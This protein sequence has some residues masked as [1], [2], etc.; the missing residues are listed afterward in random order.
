MRVQIDS[1]EKERVKS[2]SAY[3][4]SQGLDV[5]VCELESEIICSM[6]KFVL[7]LK[8]FQT[9]SQAFKTIGFLIKG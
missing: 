5:E 2:A 6:I 7:N 1:R 4:K 3:F 9:L 8:S